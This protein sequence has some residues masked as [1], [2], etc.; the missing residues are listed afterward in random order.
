MSR[1]AI[2]DWLGRGLYFQQPAD[3]D[4][5]ADKQLARSWSRL[6]RIAFDLRAGRSDALPGLWALI[7]ETSDPHEL[8]VALHLIGAAGQ[9]ADV[10]RLCAFMYD[11]DDVEVLYYAAEGAL[12]SGH[13]DLVD[14]IQQAWE[15][16]D[17]VDTHDAFG[18]ILSYLLEQTT[19][20]Q[21]VSTV[22]RAKPLTGPLADKQRYPRLN[23][24]HEILE[25]F[26]PPLPHMVDEKFKNLKL[27]FNIHSCRFWRG[28]PL[29]VYQIA[30]EFMERAYRGAAFPALYWRA[31]FETLSGADCRRMFDERGRFL[32]LGAI[33][34]IEEFLAQGDT[35]FEDGSLYFCGR[36]VE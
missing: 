21:Q 33:A 23:E 13:L 22:F 9:R 31:R 3:G 16:C 4:Q 10:E 27:H 28:R 29:S 19:D 8:R 18:W 20:I 6:E 34:V 24:L 17:T 35:H 26:D 36:L 1:D 30:E 14:P 25:T 7:D 11:E 2:G 12:L 15:I 32:Q 5:A